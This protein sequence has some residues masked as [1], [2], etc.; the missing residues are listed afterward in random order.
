ML[1]E[2]RRRGDCL[3]VG[4]SPAHPRTTSGSP[5]TSF[6][7]HSQIPIPRAVHDGVF[8]REVLEAGLLAGHDHIDVVPAP[9]AVVGDGEQRVRVRRQVDADDLRLLIHDVVDE[10]RVLVREPVEWSWR[11][12]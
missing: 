4:M 12:T 1:A 7:A 5:S 3:A 10:A 6:E 8:N 2:E 9:E 11:Q